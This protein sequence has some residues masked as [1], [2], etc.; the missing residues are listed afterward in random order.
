MFLQGWGGGWCI[1]CETDN[2]VIS[3]CSLEIF[4]DSPAN[5]TFHELKRVV[6]DSGGSGLV[7]SAV[8]SQRE[9]NHGRLLHRTDLYP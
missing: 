4:W 5:S 7:Y 3:R 9:Q 2:K 6:L 1:Y 8:P